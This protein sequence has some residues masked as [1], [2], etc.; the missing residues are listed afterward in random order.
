MAEVLSDHPDLSELAQSP[1]PGQKRKRDMSE[2]TSPGRAK[3]TSAGPDADT[4]AFIENAIE[5]AN[6]AAANG[7]NVADFSA[8]QQAAA[9][10]H[11]EAA[12]PA[13]A[14]STAAAALGMYPTLHVPPTTEEQ[15]AAQAANEPP[16]Q[17]HFPS[18][19]GLMSS[20]P[21][22]PQPTNGVQGVPQP[23]HQTHQP[24]PPQPPQHRYST[25]SAST[26]AKKPDVG[27]E[28][29]HKMRKDN[30][31]EVERRRRETINEGINELAK[32]VPNCEKNKG[33]I[34]QR[35]VT[36]INQLKENENQN[37]E[38]WTLEKLLTEQAI[39]ELSASNDKLKQECERLYKELE[40][41][42]RVAQNAGLSYPQ[43][44][45]DE[46]AAAT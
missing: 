26:P 3:R 44:N 4:T 21:N 9:A 38:K 20:L 19:D 39:A 22:V 13:N 28:E 45:K 25:G 11:S 46:P 30:H 29:W 24:P 1:S 8:L 16:H 18:P 42:K 27:S 41:W 10:E 43:A 2:S 15:F 7:V 32:I 5:A 36:F 12:D 6:A 31:K 40:T 34:L 33:S 37:I 35:A 14:S 17:D 23:P